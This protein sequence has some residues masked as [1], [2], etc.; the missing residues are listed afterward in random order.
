MVLRQER[1]PSLASSFAKAPADKQ[2]KGCYTGFL[3]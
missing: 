1:F 3:R 2:V